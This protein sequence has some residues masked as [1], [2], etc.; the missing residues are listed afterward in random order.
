MLAKPW[1]LRLCFLCRNLDQQGRKLREDW[2]D[3]V[4][5]L[6]KTEEAEGHYK[7]ELHKV[8]SNHDRIILEHN[9]R[10]LEL[11]CCEETEESFAS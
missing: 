1:F 10:I 3:K 9:Q 8:W 6:T 11:V 4:Y 2:D 5:K 7:N